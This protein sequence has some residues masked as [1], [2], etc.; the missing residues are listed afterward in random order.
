MNPTIESQRLPGGMVGGENPSR[1]DHSRTS[2]AEPEA[3]TLPV[4][5]LSHETPPAASLLIAERE[6]VV[7]LR[8]R[9]FP[10]LRDLILNR[11]TEAEA[12]AFGDLF[13]EVEGLSNM[14]F[15]ARMKTLI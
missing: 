8:A 6:Q 1:I 7:A 3:E 12:A 9:L 14:I 4:R 11:P 13:I 5:L 15:E 2:V 10:I